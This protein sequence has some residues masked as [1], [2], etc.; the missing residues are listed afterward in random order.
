MARWM[1]GQIYG[2][3]DGWSDLW[4]DGWLVRWMDGWP[5]WM[6]G[7]SLPNLAGDIYAYNFLFIQSRGIYVSFK[8]N[9]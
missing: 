7:V 3:M 6:D 1:A 4:S 5:G 9:L 2:Q 8:V